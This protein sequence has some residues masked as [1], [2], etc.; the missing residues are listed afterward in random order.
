MKIGSADDLENL[1]MAKFREF[2]A[3]YGIFVEYTIDRAARDIGLHFT[4]LSAAG[5]RV[6]TPALVWFQMK[7][8]SAAKLSRDQFEAADAV[9][10]SLETKHLR[11]W[12]VALEP[13]YVVVYIESADQFLVVN[14]KEWV[15]QKLGE[16][17]LTTSQES[18]SV[19]I[20]KKNELDD[21]AFRI[22][23][24]KNL[25]SVVRDRLR[26][27]DDGEAQRFLA[28]AAIVKWMD[29]CRQSGVKTRIAVKAWISKTRMEFVF[30]SQD[31][32]ED[33]KPVRLHW[34][35]HTPPFTRVFPF[36]SFSGGRLARF[37]E[38]VTLDYFAGEPFS[39]THRTI[40]WLDPAVAEEMDD[41]E[42]ENEGWLDLGGDL[43]TYGDIAAG[44]WTEH[45]LAISL[46]DLGESW[47]AILKVM[48]EAE[49]LAVE[50][51]EGWVSVAPW[52]TRDL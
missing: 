45:E 42:L 44:E 41:E 37:Q 31:P 9:T 29:Q 35:V 28:A 24:H 22:I 20:G 6:V 52:N 38:T 40:D 47:L 32:G 10:L 46:N 49:I 8:V 33:W 18:Y 15:G 23:L 48:E 16:E 1:Y 14:I 25:C 12:H 19:R 7:G 21:H 26:A 27:S 11:F 50:N 3:N 2:A 17:V 13:T 34:Q 5:G 51:V 30:L 4:Q 36:L 43:Y 39:E